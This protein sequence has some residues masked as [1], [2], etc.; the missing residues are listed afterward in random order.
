MSL[1][2][3]EMQLCFQRCSVSAV[4]SDLAAGCFVGPSTMASLATLSACN[5]HT[6]PRSAA[7]KTHSSGKPK[8]SLPMRT[9]PTG[10]GR[11]LWHAQVLGDIC[12]R[13]KSHLRAIY[14]SRA[15]QAADLVF[16]NHRK[17]QSP[18]RRSECS[19]RWWHRGPCSAQCNERPASATCSAVTTK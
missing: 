15:W 4:R 13:R 7:F 5:P 9:I 3:S 1:H 2:F 8:R 19:L 16:L 17:L 6:D 11:P 12:T 14:S 10:C 18:V